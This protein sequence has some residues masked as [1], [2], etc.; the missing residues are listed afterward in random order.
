MKNKLIFITILILNTF[1]CKQPNYETIYI[2]EEMKTYIDFPVG[3]YWVY[4]DSVTSEIDSFYLNK[5]DI[6]FDRGPEGESFE[7]ECLE[8]FY[9][10]EKSHDS[11]RGAGIR[12]YT[13]IGLYYDSYFDSRFFNNTKEGDTIRIN[14]VNIIHKKTLPSLIISGNEFNNVI[15]FVEGNYR[16]CYWCKNIGIVRHEIYKIENEIGSAFIDT[17]IINNLTNYKIN[18]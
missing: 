8:Q 14:G 4:K 18:N 12:Y 10:N 16:S 9:Y 1:M 2:P 6:Y 5:S 15:L 13:N 17:L 7:F 11:I 3:S